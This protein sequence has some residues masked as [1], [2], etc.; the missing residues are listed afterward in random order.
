MKNARSVEVGFFSVVQTE[1][2]QSL[3]SG[4]NYNS[5][6]SSFFYYF[7]Q[8]CTYHVVDIAK[9]SSAMVIPSY[10]MII[11]VSL[12]DFPQSNKWSR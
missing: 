7:V 12:E 4:K 5:N 1:P 8:G 3:Y 11:I 9:Q 2:F 6:K 10:Q